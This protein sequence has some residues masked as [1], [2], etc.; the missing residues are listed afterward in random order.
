MTHTVFVICSDTTHVS[1]CTNRKRKSKA[2]ARIAHYCDSLQIAL[3]HNP[4]DTDWQYLSSSSNL[5]LV[6]L[7]HLGEEDSR[8]R[9][10]DRTPA[11]I[12]MLVR[13]PV[14]QVFFEKEGGIA[15]FLAQQLDA[16]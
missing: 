12:W 15:P 1:D 8:S 3:T 7:L 9:E 13:L 4:S 5:K 6:M 10:R 14:L 11:N 16:F 2:L